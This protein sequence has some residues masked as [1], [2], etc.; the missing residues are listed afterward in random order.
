[1]ADEQGSVS[2]LHPVQVALAVDQE[3]QR[4]VRV[5]EDRL[6]SSGYK[7]RAWAYRIIRNVVPDMTRARWRDIV[8][9]SPDASLVE[10][11]CRCDGCFD[12][13][14]HGDCERCDDHGC[15]QCYPDHTVYSCCGYCEDCDEHMDDDLDEEVCDRGHCHTCDHQCR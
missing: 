14:C 7:Y 1:M 13:Q 10:E 6:S 8:G 15:E 2:T 9:R 12:D 11:A 3:V 4:L 5:T